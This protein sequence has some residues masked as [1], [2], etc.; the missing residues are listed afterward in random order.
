MSRG[1][2]TL[3]TTIDFN[4]A[5]ITSQTKRTCAVTWLRRVRSFGHPNLL[6]ILSPIIGYVQLVIGFC[7]GCTIFDKSIL[8][9]PINIYNIGLSRLRGG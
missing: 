9:A 8:I 5:N 7:P 3:E 6:T 1:F 2:S 4:I